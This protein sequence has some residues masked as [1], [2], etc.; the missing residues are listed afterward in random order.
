MSNKLL[1]IALIGAAIFGS[2]SANA[3]CPNGQCG[4]RSARVAYNNYG[5]NYTRVRLF[6]GGLFNRAQCA[7]GQC[8]LFSRQASYRGQCTTE[9]CYSGQ[10]STGNC[11]N[12]QCTLEAVNELPPAPCA[13]TMDEVETPAP[14]KAVET[15]EELNPCSSVETV[16]EEPVKPCGAVQ[17]VETCT[18]TV[19][20]ETTPG[21]GFCGNSECKRQT[22]VDKIRNVVANLPLFNSIN[23]VRMT[24]LTFDANLSAQAKEQASRMARQGFLSHM[25]G[26]AEI[27][28]YCSD[29]NQAVNVWL[30]SGAHRRI[31]LAGYT[32][33]GT[34]FCKDAYGRVW[35]CARFQ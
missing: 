17:T 1:A 35:C 4:L 9:T 34:G 7:N 12:G 29:V 26:S 31:M 13:P 33:C 24:R 6:N 23:R 28:C 20:G 32:R 25:G 22:V 14:C 2:N 18:C 16:V 10:C 15:V 3:Q 11:A 30:S 27:C 19:C 5:V 21:C 8:G